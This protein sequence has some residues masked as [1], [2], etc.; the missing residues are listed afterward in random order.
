MNNKGKWIIPFSEG[1]SNLQFINNGYI[2]VRKGSYFGIITINKIDVISINRGYTYISDYDKSKHTFAFTKKGYTGECDAQGREI[3]VTK[4]PP[5]ANDIK[6]T[7]SYAS[8]VELKNGSTKY[9][10][11]NKGGR[12]G[13]TDAEGK[14]I[15]PAEMEALESAGSGYLRYKLN[16]FW[17]LMNY[18][19]KI[20]IDTD[21]GYTSIGDFKT[22][23]K[24]FAYTMNG[25]KGECDATGRQI[26]KIKVD[27]PP[28]QATASSSTS[29][30]SSSS[31]SNSSSTSNSGNKT[32][33][34]VVEHHRDPVPVHEWQQC[35]ACYG[36]GQC[37]YVQCGG[38]GWYYIG[39]RRSL[40]SRCHGSGKCTTCAGR[41]C[42]N[43]TVYR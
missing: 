22:F 23:N 12:Y 11:V 15:I 31:S 39:D 4:L 16:G 5:T 40:C 26:S 25:Y 18:T 34:V 21:R 42:Q 2:Q 43:V 8:A 9:W 30:S 13:L 1:Y 24:R 32:T 41:G 28:Q 29:S 20:L 14:I 33:T 37:P 27:T 17:G 6:A 7:G 36:S 35:P 19:G 38:S 3:S 10:K